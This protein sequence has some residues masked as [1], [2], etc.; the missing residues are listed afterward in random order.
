[1]TIKQ[2]YI[3]LLIGVL[4]PFFI[5]IIGGLFFALYNG[6][7]TKR[8]LGGLTMIIGYGLPI[9]FIPLFIYSLLINSIVIPKLYHCTICIMIIS[10]LLGILFPLIPMSIGGSFDLVS[11]IMVFI[12]GLISGYILKS[13]YPTNRGNLNDSK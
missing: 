10:A 7:E 11:I 4:L 9:M 1:M 2:A 12:I 3:R 8:L 13:I 5:Y 6:E